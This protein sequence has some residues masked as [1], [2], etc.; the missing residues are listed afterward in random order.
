[1]VAEATASKKQQTKEQQKQDDKTTPLSLRA[2]IE[3]QG[4]KMIKDTQ[5][6]FQEQPQSRKVKSPS[7]QLDEEEQQSPLVQ[8]QEQ[9]QLHQ[10]QQQAKEQHPQEISQPEVQQRIND[11]AS[12]KVQEDNEVN[13]G[14]SQGSK[15][16]PL[17]LRARIG[18][19]GKKLIKDTQKQLQEQQQSK[20]VRS[21]SAKST[22]E[23]QQ[24]FKK[25]RSPSA[26]LTREL[27]MQ[28]QQLGEPSQGEPE[29]QVENV[30]DSG[31]QSHEEE[32]SQ[33][34][35]PKAM[36]FRA[37]IEQQGK[38]GKKLA[39]DS[40]QKQFQGQQQQPNKVRNPSAKL[41][42]ESQLQQLQQQEQEVSQLQYLDG[43]EQQPWQD[44]NL[45]KDPPYE[46]IIDEVNDDGIEVA[47]G[48]AKKGKGKI[49][50]QSKFAQGKKLI[51]DAQKNI[52]EQARAR[53]ELLQQQQQQQH[54]QQRRRDS[55]S[56]IPITI[57]GK[58]R[59][60]KMSFQDRLAQGRRLIKDSQKAVLSKKKGR[61]LSNP[62]PP[63]KIEDAPQV[64]PAIQIHSP[65]KTER[66]SLE[67]A[68]EQLAQEEEERMSAKAGSRTSLAASQGSMR[69]VEEDAAA[70]QR[71]RKGVPRTP[72]QD[73][74]SRSASLEQKKVPP[75]KE[76]AKTK[77]KKSKSRTPS[78]DQNKP[79][80]GDVFSAISDTTLSAGRRGRSRSKGE[81]QQPSKEDSAELYASVS[82]R[83][84]RSPMLQ[85]P[86]PTEPPEPPTAPPFTTFV[87]R[88]KSRSSE[89]RLTGSADAE[90]VARARRQQ[91]L[92]AREEERMDALGTMDSGISM[93]RESSSGGTLRL[94]RKRTDTDECVRA[95]V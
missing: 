1:M 64:V 73:G 72:D 78:A 79:A 23:K 36:S 15:P 37:R 10:Q 16:P 41:T 61:S 33:E 88:K 27:E 48:S 84:R 50:L 66:V 53:N 71:P 34:S 80:V 22:E 35:K 32:H 12:K 5:K 91:E 4:K 17:S 44:E 45:E 58:E 92:G 93:M 56:D 19:Q 49:S 7:A 94:A 24:E 52:Q 31:K 30:Y 60:G 28:Q 8:Q 46:T 18:Q 63:L 39:K 87:P 69:K 59:Q 85:Q 2:R 54:Q 3:E 20:R 14:S 81:Q 25:V 77:K 40:L 82:F 43:Q 76:D 65:S 57:E 75:R 68:F 55:T 51:K 62:P 9:H 6:Q 29:Q 42:E 86:L 83:G 13:Q 95:S 26:Q 47:T 67:E 21:N 70:P 74:R 90:T 11:A 89:R 38:K